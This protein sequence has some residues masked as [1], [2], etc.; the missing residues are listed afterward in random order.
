MDSSA[1]SLELDELGTYYKFAEKSEKT[2][3][4]ERSFNDV[5]CDDAV[6]CQGREDRVVL[7]VDK[8]PPLHATL[9]HDSPSH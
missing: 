1:Q 4:G 7:A 3:S 6:E 2:R 9:A 8:A 5:I